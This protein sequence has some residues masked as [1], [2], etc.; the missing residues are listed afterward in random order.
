MC[1][2]PGLQTIHSEIMDNS[3]EVAWLLSVSQ[4]HRQWCC[5]L[6]ARLFKLEELLTHSKNQIWWDKALRVN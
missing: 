5:L 1:A 6:A 3:Q 4:A 2:L